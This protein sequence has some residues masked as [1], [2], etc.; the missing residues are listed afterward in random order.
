MKNIK[1]EEKFS[2]YINVNYVIGPT[3]WDIYHMLINMAK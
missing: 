1:T 2:G 3:D